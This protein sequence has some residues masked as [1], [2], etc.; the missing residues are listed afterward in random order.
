VGELGRFFSGIGVA[1]L[2]VGAWL[3]LGAL[4][5]GGA[6][7]LAF[8]TSGIALGLAGIA[9]TWL[10]RFLRRLDS[11][12]LLKIGQPATARVL[13]VRDTGLTVN[14][15]YAGFE[16]S[17]EVHPP[18][19]PVYTVQTRTLLERTQWGTLQPGMVV[20]VRID[21]RNPQR[22]AIESITA[23]QASQYYIAGVQRADDIIAQDLHAEAEVL[24]VQ[25]TGAQAAQ[26][27]PGLALRPDQADDPVMVVRLRVLPP[28]GAPFEAESALRVPD[29]KAH[30]LV[31]GQRVPV[32][33]L[34]HDPART[35]TLH[36]A[37]IPTRS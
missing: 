6:T 5:Q 25:S 27:S 9:F 10:G 8:N 34:P 32:A 22:V 7:S 3:L 31:V 19:R 13:A 23:G 33:Y 18:D 17:L 4:F 15:I 30:A 36:W 35:T 12:D 37:R 28:T 16:L 2:L 24:A 20:Q 29:G 26:L 1:V 21:P 14:N 11:T